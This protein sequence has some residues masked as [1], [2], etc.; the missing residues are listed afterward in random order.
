[1]SEDGTGGRRSKR[2][3]AAAAGV[4]GADPNRSAAGPSEGEQSGGA[5]EDAID[6]ADH[7]DALRARR[8]AL[9][10]REAAVPT[11]LA[12]AEAALSVAVAEAESAE[13]PP[14]DVRGAL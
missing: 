7:P 12:E 10:A 8:D 4:V 2:A 9:E 13:P 3:P 6:A 1:M 14:T 11:R 5:L